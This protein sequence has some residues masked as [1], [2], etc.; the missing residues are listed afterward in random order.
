MQIAQRQRIETAGMI[1]FLHEPVGKDIL[2]VEI[3]AVVHFFADVFEFVGNILQHSDSALPPQIS[4]VNHDDVVSRAAVNGRAYNAVARRKS[5]A[6]GTSPPRRRFGKFQNILGLFY[7]CHI[8][9]SVSILLCQ[10][11]C[12]IP[13]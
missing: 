4:V 12:I 7:R 10:T 3:C 6:P 9:L 13:F 1:T 5:F 11:R 8:S 2:G